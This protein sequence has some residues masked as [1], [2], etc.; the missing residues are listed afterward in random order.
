LGGQNLVKFQSEKYDLDQHKG[1][2]M[3]GGKKRRPN[4]PDFEKKIPRTPD[5][6]YKFH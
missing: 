5:F 4:S 6:Y 2:S 1:F 3:G